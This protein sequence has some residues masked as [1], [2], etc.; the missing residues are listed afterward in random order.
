MLLEQVSEQMRD[1]RDLTVTGAAGATER[2]QGYS[3][4]GESVDADLLVM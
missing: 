3:Q 4:S 2:V 1:R